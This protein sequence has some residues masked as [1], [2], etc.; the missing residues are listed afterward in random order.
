MNE[1]ISNTHR[2]YQMSHLVN[3]VFS[4][5]I[6]PISE[7]ILLFYR[8]FYTLMFSIFKRFLKYRSFVLSIKACKVQHPQPDAIGYFSLFFRKC[9]PHRFY[10]NCKGFSLSYESTYLERFWWSQLFF[11][12]FKKGH[13]AYT[14][15]LCPWV[16]L[17]L[18]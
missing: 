7:Q 2:K 17:G 13:S 14:K 3:S 15:N 8:D 16:Y 6:F 18:G 12:S 9:K 1:I 10:D 4:Y 11:G 5:F